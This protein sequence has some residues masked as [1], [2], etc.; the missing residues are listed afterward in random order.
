[1]TYISELEFMRS[2]LLIILKR[3]KSFR[4]ATFSIFS[5]CL[6]ELFK[7]ILI[8]AIASIDLWVLFSTGTSAPTRR[9]EVTRRTPTASRRRGPPTP[10]SVSRQVSSLDT[11]INSDQYLLKILKKKIFSIS[12]V[13]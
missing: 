9:M 13:C 12:S 1:M 7:H 3:N 6:L 10:P 11:T 8:F 5:R 4:H 2:Y